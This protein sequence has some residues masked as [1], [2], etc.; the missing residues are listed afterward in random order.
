MSRSAGV[1]FVA[2]LA[3]LSCD[4]PVVNPPPPANPPQVFL[5]VTENNVIGDAVKG[6]VN[7]S[8]CKTVTQVQI[9]Q[10]DSF[11]ADV[12]FTKSPT[13][14]SLPAGLFSA[15]Y[16]RLGIAASLTLKAKVVCDDGRTNTSQPVGVSFFPIAQRFT[17][18]DGSQVVPDF[19][20]AEGGIGGQATTY[21]GC[22]RVD[23]G[24]TIVRVDKQGQVLGFVAAMPFDCSLAAQISDLSTSSGYRWVF[25]PGVGAF[26]LCLSSACGNFSVGKKLLNSKATRIG[27]GKSGVAVVWV[28]ES[29]S[30][31]RIVKMAPGAADTSND[32]EQ[33]FDNIMNSTPVVDDGVGQAVW[34]SRWEFNVGTRK[35]GIVPYKHSLA[36]GSILNGVVNGVPAVILTQQY[37]NSAVSE[38]LMPEGVFSA[39]GDTFTIPAY[40]YDTDNNIRTTVLSCS[41]SGGLCEG[42]ARRWTSANFLAGIRLIVPYSSGNIFAAIGPYHVY[43]LNAQTGAVMNLGEQ[44]ISPTGSQIVLGVQAGGGADFYVLTGPDFGPMTAAF[45][46]EIIAVDTPQTGEVWRLQYG[47][48][49]APTNGVTIAI[50]DSFQPW[51]RVG[52]DLIKPLA[53]A[54]YRMARG[55]TMVP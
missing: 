23:I 9:L 7:V 41:T 30:R 48:G 44:A 49:E 6:K 51:L 47:S 34:V 2:S 26:A 25:E 19:F 43:F 52:T 24:T 5:T 20:L 29:A 31:N 37:P 13:D 32:W 11:L 38:P 33:P 35:A 12:N 36:N 54:E 39:T 15:L 16:S 45:P 22:A 10:Q 8:G 42:A 21:L 40:S 55:A 14:F 3:L 28:N 50:D 27:V 46:T 18:L 4:P 17:A 1:V 53:N